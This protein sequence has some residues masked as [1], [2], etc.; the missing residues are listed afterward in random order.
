MCASFVSAGAVEGI[1]GGVRNVY[2]AIDP[3][4]RLLVGDT[5]LS[6][7]LFLA[8]VLL[9][10]IIFG[11]VWMALNKISFFQ[12]YAWVLWTVTIAVSLLAIRWIGDASV[13]NTI[14]LPYSA[15]GVALTAGIPFV[16]YFLI[17][18]DFQRTMRKLSWV[19]FSVIF[20]SLWVM[21]SGK[22]AEG[23]SVIG[24]PV[25]AFSWIYLATA[26]LGLAVLTFD[27]TIQKI[28]NKIE[29]EKQMSYKDLERKHRLLDELDETRELKSKLIS[30]NAK[31][32]EIK[33]I[34]TRIDR[35]EKEIAKL[36]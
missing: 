27:G 7:E 5:G 3:F 28:L 33:S 22:V 16:I 21:R 36:P 14:I 23:T 24:G 35:L 6:T 25:G 9:A 20:F 11:I 26:V 1:Q 4:L 19:F 34:E 18:K 15:L 8:K 30:R 12:E 13:I 29:I 10:I 31:I 2:T 32:S 17:V